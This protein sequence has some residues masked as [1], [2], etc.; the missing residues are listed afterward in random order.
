MRKPSP[1]PRGQRRRL[2]LMRV[3]HAHGLSLVV[4]IVILLQI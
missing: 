4:I 2:S 1:V 3:G